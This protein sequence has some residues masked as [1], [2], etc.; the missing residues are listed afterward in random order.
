MHRGS[1][2]K[3]KRHPDRHC[4][5]HRSNRGIVESQD[6]KCLSVS[7]AHAVDILRRH[8]ASLLARRMPLIW[9]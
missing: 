9:P 2:D 3:N 4:H 7:S 6:L 5:A 1:Q 8:D